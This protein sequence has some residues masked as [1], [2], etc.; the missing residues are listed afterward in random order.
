MWFGV[1]V[2]NIDTENIEDEVKSQVAKYTCPQRYRW[3]RFWGSVGCISSRAALQ[4]DVGL[5][6]GMIS[7]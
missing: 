7:A 2:D 1:I 3:D 6:V 5:S 4:V